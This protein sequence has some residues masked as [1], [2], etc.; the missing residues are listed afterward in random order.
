[1]GYYTSNFSLYKSLKRSIDFLVIF[2]ALVG[3]YISWIYPQRG[4][5]N[6]IVVL[7]SNEIKLIDLINHQ[8]PLAILLFNLDK[9]KQIDFTSLLTILI[10]FAFYFLSVED[11]M[12]NYEISPE[13]IT[14]FVLISL[15][16]SL[17]MRLK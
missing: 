16:I 4:I 17:A 11:P 3:S 8:L 5:C 9:T 14:V 2:V 13:L 7:N 6:G 1:M 15:A 10:L 12:R